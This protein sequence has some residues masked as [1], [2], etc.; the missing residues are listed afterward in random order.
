MWE[1]D[2]GKINVGQAL[3]VACSCGHRRPDSDFSSEESVSSRRN[4]ERRSSR[5][6]RLADG[7]YYDDY[8]GSVF[9]R[10]KRS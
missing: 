6:K 7:R 2:S 8:E 9:D 4:E 1:D 10:R 3:G 5:M